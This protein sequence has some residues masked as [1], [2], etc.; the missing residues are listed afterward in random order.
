M[1]RTR[2]CEQ[3]I[4]GKQTSRRA[5]TMTEPVAA[6]SSTP[7]VAEKRPEEA[8]ED[9]VASK[10][11]RLETCDRDDNENKLEARL[12]GILC[13]AVCLDLPRS[14]VYQVSGRAILG[15]GRA[16]GAHPRFARP[17]VACRRGGCEAGGEAGCNVSV[18]ASKGRG[19]PR[20]AG[21]R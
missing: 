8:K 5:D 6:S 18:V 16:C 15:E 12:G 14:A 17:C 19:V 10:K 4:A 21:I 3:L 7:A 1:R 11:P 9:D 20:E 2:L 13:C